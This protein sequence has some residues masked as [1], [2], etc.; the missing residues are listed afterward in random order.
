MMNSMKA[1]R[2]FSF[3]QRSIVVSVLVGMVLISGLSEAENE[4]DRTGR[5]QIR[6]HD[7]ELNNAKK[8]GLLTVVRAAAGQLPNV[9]RSLDD[10][11]IPVLSV[12]PP[13]GV[14]VVGG[15]GVLVHLSGV[16]QGLD[17]SGGIALTP[18]LRKLAAEVEVLP[19]T[20]IGVIARFVW[21]AELEEIVRKLEGAG[22]ELR[23]V[24]SS[25]GV[26]TQLGIRVD[27]KKLGLVVDILEQSEGLV[28]ADAQPA[29]RLQNSASAWRCQS[30]AFDSTPVFNNG[31]HGD[32]QVVAV[33]DTGIDV[34]HCFFWDEI[35]GLPPV[36]DDTTTSVDTNQRKVVA[37]NFL[38]SA[39]WP[40]PGAADW[41]DQGHGTHVAG[42][43]AGDADNFG[44]HDGFDG[45]APAAKLVIQDGGFGTDDCADLP[46]LGCPLRPLYPLLEQTFLQGTHIH[47]NS[48]GDEENFFPRG[49]YTERTAEVDRF[50]WDHKEFLS[51]YAAG[52][53][54]Y[55]GDGSVISPSTGKNV[56]SVGATVHGLSEPPCPAVFSSRGWTHDDRIK[57]DVL[58]PGSSVWSAAT[59]YSVD[60]FNCNV[61]TSSGTSMA[62]PTAAGLA[63]LVRQYYVDGYYPSGLAN[64]LDGFIP[65]AALIKATLI[66]SAVDVTTLGCTEARPI[67]SPDQGW[68]LIQL[69]RALFFPDDDLRLVARDRSTGFSAATDPTITMPVSLTASGPLKAVLVWTD[70]P[71][72]ALAEENLVNDLDLMVFGPD[73]AFKGNVFS[74]GISVNGGEA[75]RLNNVEV[76]WLP[77]ASAGQWSIQVSAHEIMVPG[78]DYALVITGELA[79]DKPRRFRILSQP[80]SVKQSSP[81]HRL[82][83]SSLS[84][85]ISR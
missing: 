35:H 26:T 39:D 2:F 65:N 83:T 29:V 20:R 54:G 34:D 64:E 37:T 71:S 59:D 45:M 14:L 13:D 15:A 1:L 58:A 4:P 46:G 32:G 61:R 16:R 69:D 27:R 10:R 62:T 85:V 19:E 78:Q 81:D 23:W 36:N 55:E 63:A 42:S 38:W 75:D 33:L 84:S 51:F 6:E 9:M 44:V 66:A 25:S 73:G 70:P 80:S 3:G 31:I 57:P 79:D 60:S 53:S 72:T 43:V 67:P 7:G 17:W 76:V 21:S 11:G 77:Q 5:L 28:W 22:A 24:E 52:N 8:D 82:M 30:G 41:D 48:W 56:I 49:R 40:S 47:T 18:E 12:V 74:E 68:G 50:T